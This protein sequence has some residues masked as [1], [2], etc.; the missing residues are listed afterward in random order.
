V[1]R[2]LG[3]VYWCLTPLATLS[4]ILPISRKSVLLVLET[5]VAGGR[6]GGGVDL[7]ESHW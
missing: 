2:W 5:G 3:L 6:G 1:R 7:T 4:I